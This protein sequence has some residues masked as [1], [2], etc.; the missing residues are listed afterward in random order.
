MPHCENTLIRQTYDI[1]RCIR[2]GVKHYHVQRKQID[3]HNVGLCSKCP[4]LAQHKRASVLAIG[5]LRYQSVTAPSTH[6]A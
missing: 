6:A 3:S 5:Q 2:R 4:L 1:T